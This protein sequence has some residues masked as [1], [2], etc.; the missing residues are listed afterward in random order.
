MPNPA[1]E[2]G[3]GRESRTAANTTLMDGLYV[4]G[5]VPNIVRKRLV[6]GTGTCWLDPLGTVGMV[7]RAV[8]ADSAAR[9]GKGHDARDGQPP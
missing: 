4:A 7:A 1:A 8:K 5:A 2:M 9:L 6:G 3:L